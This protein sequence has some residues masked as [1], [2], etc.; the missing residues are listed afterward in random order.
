MSK[1]NMKKMVRDHADVLH[2]IEFALLDGHKH[3]PGIDD[4]IALDALRCM[5]NDTVPSD[6]LAIDL[7]EKLIEAREMH[8]KL[9]ELVWNECLRV[10]MDSVRRHSTLK[11]GATIYL[12][13]IAN[14]I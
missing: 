1:T 5:H 11:P 14:F 7:V 10:V 8:A 12:D 9:P 4:R 13:F 6:L 2:A 3:A